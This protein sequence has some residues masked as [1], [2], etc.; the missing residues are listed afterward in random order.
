MSP[1]QL[2][3]TKSPQLHNIITTPSY[4]P[5]FLGYDG[6]LCIQV[7]FISS[8][9]CNLY[10]AGKNYLKTHGGRLIAV[11]NTLRALVLG[12]DH[13]TVASRTRQRVFRRLCEFNELAQL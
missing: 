6:I 13:G 2:P 11:A 9:Y 10:F 5:H 7:S 1:W 3:T 12:G 8:S 4:L